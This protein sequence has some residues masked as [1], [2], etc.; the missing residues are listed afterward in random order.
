VANTYT[1]LYYHFVW[2]TKLRDP[3]I[4]AELE[5]R[6]YPYIRSRCRE[7][8]AFVHALD[9]VEDHTHLVCSLPVTV[10]IAEFLDKVKGSSS[11]F[12]NHLPDAGFRLYW[13]P[14]Y[15]ALTFAKRD[16]ARIVD[17]VQNQK[18]HHA[19]ANLWGSLER[20]D[21]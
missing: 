14:G 6:L 2:G 16:L 7:M 5:A 4:T 17:Y 20:I 3:Y 12:A 8:K 13:Q 11:H 19:I 9:G 15:G 1:Q 10:S 18:H 21:P